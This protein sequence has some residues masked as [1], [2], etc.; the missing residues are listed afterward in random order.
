[1]FSDTG[2]MDSMLPA[3]RLN[4]F[5]VKNT[6]ATNRGRGRGCESLGYCCT[7]PRTKKGKLAYEKCLLVSG[8][9]VLYHVTGTRSSLACC[10]GSAAE[11]ATVICVRAAKT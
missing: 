3:H 10:F 9:S 4:P 8:V 6:A 7:C 1:M 11:Q 2:F 5:Q